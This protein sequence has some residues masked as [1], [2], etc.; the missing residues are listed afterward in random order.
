MT[1]REHHENHDEPSGFPIR[2]PEPEFE[3]FG[4]QLEHH[5]WEPPREPDPSGNTGLAPEPFPL[6]QPSILLDLARLDLVGLVQ[7]KDVEA[8]R[9]LAWLL[10]RFA[11]GP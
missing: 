10:H 11:K 7:V 5:A 2:P 3:V 1:T 8:S 4:L 9:R 6:L